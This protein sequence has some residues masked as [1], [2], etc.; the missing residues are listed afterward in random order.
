MP[1]DPAWSQGTR[2]PIAIST[3]E[4]RAPFAG[5]SGGLSPVNFATMLLEVKSS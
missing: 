1:T 3:W 2:M 4:R 5:D